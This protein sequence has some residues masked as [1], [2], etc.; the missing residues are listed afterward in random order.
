[1]LLVG[2]LFTTYALSVLLIREPYV[3]LCSCA[4]KRLKRALR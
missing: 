3:P 1:M 4:R 2:E